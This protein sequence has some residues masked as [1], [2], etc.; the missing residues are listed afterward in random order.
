MTRH[1]LKKYLLPLTYNYTV[2]V[3]CGGEST[4]N[5]LHGLNYPIQHCLFLLIN[6]QHCAE[7]LYLTT[8]Y[9]ALI[10]HRGVAVVATQ[11]AS[12]DKIDRTTTAKH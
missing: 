9:I 8:V 12:Y 5:L 2:N 4:S 1:V 6:K 11:L 10:D 7:V 3:A